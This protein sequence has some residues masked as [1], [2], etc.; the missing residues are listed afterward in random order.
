[1]RGGDRTEQSGGRG[2]VLPGS[3]DPG[4]GPAR[5]EARPELGASRAIP[6]TVGACFFM[7][8][9]DATIIA[10]SLPQIAEALDV[11]PHETGVALTAYLI[12]LSVGMVASGWLADRFE[13]RRVF[14]L[15]IA[16]FTLGSL[17]CGLS[18]DLA[19]LVTGRFLQGLGGAMMTPVGRLILALSFPRDQLVRAMSYMLI[20]G[21]LGPM[22]GPMLGG[23]I[24]TYFDWRWIFFINIPLG[25]LGIAMAIKFLAPVATGRDT[26]FD[27]T[28]FL[29]VAVALGSIQTSLELIVAEGALG[30]VPVLGLALGLAA[31][32]AYLRHA[33]S[34]DPIL[35]LRLFRYRAFAVAV[36]GGSFARVVLGST[37]FLFPLYFQ[38]GMGLAPIEAGYLMAALALGQIALRVVID[39]LLKQLGVK[40]LLIANSIVVGAVLPALLLFE[41]ADAFWALGGFLFFFGM[42]QAV[43]LSILGSLNFSAIP[44][45]VMGRATTVA[46][47]VQR[48]ATAVGISLAAI[49]LGQA[50]GSDQS[51]RSDFMLPVLA[52]SVIMLLSTSAY[53][54]LRSGDGE[55]LVARR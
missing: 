9:L 45:D 24:T 20:P 29:L 26:R 52:L 8:G 37:M 27:I 46:A 15:S 54:A 6:L 55:D 33:R 1:M 35:D 22:L 40:K 21:L 10:T 48:V 3:Q 4:A 38:L 39:P 43:H 49:L 51:I 5:D 36:L 32:C 34:A 42:L 28:G 41:T 2:T 18:S 50:A 23:A 47:V 53:F 31:C 7:E 14:I 19:Q 13:A 12:S 44:V 25:A 17:V 30:Q 16:V 11:T